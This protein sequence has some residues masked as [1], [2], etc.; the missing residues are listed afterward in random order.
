MCSS[1]S[2]H[3]HLHLLLAVNCG[4][5]WAQGVQVT[6]G[7]QLLAQVLPLLPGHPGAPTRKTQVPLLL[8]SPQVGLPGSTAT[9]DVPDQT[10]RMVSCARQGRANYCTSLYRL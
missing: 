3:Q 8:Y 4:G 2:L 6:V 10:A 9:R 5:L 1:V 7:S